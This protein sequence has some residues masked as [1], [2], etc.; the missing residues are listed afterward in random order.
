VSCTL[1]SAPSQGGDA[2]AYQR[3]GFLWNAAEKA[4][5][6]VQNFGEYIHDPFNLASNA[7]EWDQWYAE[8]QWLENG[9]KGAEPISNPCQ[10]VRAQADIPSLQKITEPCFPNFQLQI[11]DQYR[12]DEWL[13]TFKQQEHSG[14]MPSLRF[15][16]LMTDHTQSTFPGDTDPYPVAEVA[17]ND[18]AVGRVIDTISHSRFWKSTAI[19]I[20]EDDTQNGVDHVDGHRGPAFVIS[21]YSASGVDD[22]YYTQLNMVRTIE[23]ILG[24]QP[25]NQEDLA[26]EPMYSAFTQHPNNAPYNVQPTQVPLNLGAPGGP[27]T[28]TAAPAGASA[29]ERK[30]FS[31][32]G[33]VPADMRSVYAA[34]AAWSRQQVVEH[35][36]DG[37]DHVNPRLMNRFDWYSA[38]DWRVAYPG[39]PKIYAPDQV[40]GRNLPAAYLGDG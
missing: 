5:L 21:P 40:P 32:Q 10:W 28:L 25:M 24:I 4:G 33:V 17:D 14:S 6:S 34:W 15:M 16:W 8:S 13:P 9:Q 18:L 22:G 23:Q 31:R 20:V 30:A 1:R 37:P 27:T 7:P 26:A 2:L 39:D 3:D 36:F 35:H 38:H 11:P 12:V 29:A 19:F